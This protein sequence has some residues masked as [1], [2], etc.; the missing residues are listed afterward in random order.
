MPRDLTPD[1]IAV[2]QRQRGTAFKAFTEAAENRRTSTA[3]PDE[4]SLGREFLLLTESKSLCMTILTLENSIEYIKSLVKRY[5]AD[6][7][8]A[9]ESDESVENYAEADYLE[10]LNEVWEGAGYLGDAMKHMVTLACGDAAVCVLINR[11]CDYLST[12]QANQ[13]PKEQKEALDKLLKDRKLQEQLP[14]LKVPEKLN[15]QVIDEL[16]KIPDEL[17]HDMKKLVKAINTISSRIDKENRQDYNRICNEVE[18]VIQSVIS[19]TAPKNT[20]QK[21]EL[22]AG[23]IVHAYENMPVEKVS[24]ARIQ[25][26]YI[27]LILERNKIINEASLETVQKV[28]ASL[29]D[30]AKSLDGLIDIYSAEMRKA[31]Y[32]NTPVLSKIDNNKQYFHSGDF[33][34]ALKSLGQAFQKMNIDNTLAK[35][36]DGSIEGVSKKNLSTE[37]SSGI[38]QSQDYAK[39]IDQITSFLVTPYALSLANGNL[40][41]RERI[42]L[43]EIYDET[44]HTKL[45][46]EKDGGIFSSNADRL[47]YTQERFFI[48][49]EHLENMFSDYGD[50]IKTAISH[51]PEHK[52]LE[53]RD[54]LDDFSHVFAMSNYDIF[55][56]K[57][58]DSLLS[59]SVEMIEKT[60]EKLDDYDVT[61]VEAS[62]NFIL[63]DI[64]MKNNTIHELIT[65]RSVT[66]V[67]SKLPAS[68][69]GIDGSNEALNRIKSKIEAQKKKVLSEKTQILT[70]QCNDYVKKYGNTKAFSTL[71]SKV[72]SPIAEMSKQFNDIENVIKGI[73]QITTDDPNVRKQFTDLQG[74]I[75]GTANEL[76][77]S[78]TNEQDI[79]SEKGIKILSQR[80]IQVAAFA[81]IHNS[82][83]LTGDE[84]FKPDNIAVITLGV[85]PRLISNLLSQS[86]LN[87][88]GFIQILDVINNLHKVEIIS[89]EQHE[90]LLENFRKEIKNTGKIIESLRVINKYD[91]E[92]SFEPLRQDCNL[93]IG[94]SKTIK[95]KND[96]N[97]DQSMLL[98]AGQMDIDIR[99]DSPHKNDI[100]KH[101]IEYV[102]AHPF[103]VIWLTTRE[104]DRL[105]TLFEST[106]RYSF[107]VADI[108]VYVQNKEKGMT[109]FEKQLEDLNKINYENIAK[110][111]QIENYVLTD[112]LTP[113]ETVEQN[114]K[115]SDKSGLKEYYTQQCLARRT[116]N[117]AEDIIAFIGKPTTDVES[118]LQHFN[119]IA[120]SSPEQASRVSMMMAE[121]FA[122]ELETIPYA[123]AFYNA[124][125]MDS[126]SKL[127]AMKTSIMLQHSYTPMIA[128]SA[129]R[130]K[131]TKLLLVS[132]K[133]LLTLA[134]K[135]TTIL[136]DV[137]EH[138]KPLRKDKENPLLRFMLIDMI[139]TN[140]KFLNL[141]LLGREDFEFYTDSMVDGFFEQLPDTRE[142]CERQLILLTGA[143]TID[144]NVENLITAIELRMKAAHRNQWPLPQD[145]YI[146]TVKLIAGLPKEHAMHANPLLL[147]CLEN[148]KLK[149]ADM[150]QRDGAYV[151]LV[152]YTA[153]CVAKYPAEA[154]SIINGL[155]NAMPNKFLDDPHSTETYMALKPIRD[156]ITKHA[157][158]MDVDRNALLKLYPFLIKKNAGERVLMKGGQAVGQVLWN[159]VTE[160]IT[161]AISG[162]AAP[163]TTI[164]AKAADKLKK[165]V[166]GG[167]ASAWEFTT[168]LVPEGSPSAASSSKSAPSTHEFIQAYQ[169][170]FRISLRELKEQIQGAGKLDS[171][172]WFD[173]LY[174]RIQ[175]YDVLSKEL[176][177]LSRTAGKRSIKV[178]GMKYAGP[179]SD[180]E[181]GEVQAEVATLRKE[182]QEAN[183]MIGDGQLS[184][185][186]RYFINKHADYSADYNKAGANKKSIETRHNA[187]K[188][189]AQNFIRLIDMVSHECTKETPSRYEFMN[190]FNQWKHSNLNT[191]APDQ[192]GPSSGGRKIFT[193]L[194]DSTLGHVPLVG[195]Y[196]KSD[197][198][199]LQ[200]QLSG[201]ALFDLAKTP[202]GREKLNEH[203]KE[204]QKFIDTPVGQVD[205]DLTGGQPGADPK[206]KSTDTRR[207]SK[208]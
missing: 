97:L 41:E 129:G 115:V 197:H 26:I 50:F 98:S 142:A 53:S 72:R 189:R 168:S 79:N 110:L 1:Q 45:S 118:Y 91:L 204:L 138:L 90:A 101:S 134:S 51:L 156:I 135:K 66:I 96:E 104:H 77:N 174:Y 12:I 62:I 49:H 31:T 160:A 48:A 158:I 19:G 88:R 17:K 67:K 55:Y 179:Q 39:S 100:L 69:S 132:V 56:K 93:L 87:E 194:R 52:Y 120:Q 37:I 46:K 99:D 14:E 112:N 188:V 13:P 108:E 178:S 109:P 81:K 116:W 172:K 23:Q 80:M 187:N 155:I 161:A 191:S 136:P 147:H 162:N 128:S 30:R 177:T 34:D 38:S 106:D 167:A 58:F 63:K 7:M 185:V 127:S 151:K 163:I 173:Q 76:S 73:K 65:D 196:M 42:V 28:R 190:A 68:L 71:S 32:S 126:P 159:P 153:H 105:N 144:K 18:K 95:L 33:G 117:K 86:K 149:E 208:R 78:L 181:F 4:A 207:K 8:L 83:S 186:S 25:T 130:D 124:I 82:L 94:V 140:Q 119:L 193:A 10:S 111:I 184:A 11:A 203:K 57:M 74:L 157:P 15:D 133:E 70:K 182:L 44:G 125:P 206:R 198:I 47:A 103:A 145:M 40:P 166:L 141:G 60:C 176:D 114:I 29:V 200:Q 6:T 154:F 75:A 192:G 16:E 202:E 183:A 148:I 27:N 59:K 107:Q 165:T 201:D 164:A 9:Q 21:F 169:D 139:Y 20:A 102:K 195:G 35:D 123:I 54:N 199:Y 150:L 171:R 64:S 137:R 84:K 85:I 170:R 43:K 2:I 92:D 180:A 175:T 5:T 205:I 3:A 143:K 122:G 152:T 131:A 61:E 113:L 36:E 121:Y 22:L 146:G 24:P 89:D